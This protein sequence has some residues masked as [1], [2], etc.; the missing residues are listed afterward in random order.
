[1]ELPT[2]VPV[3]CRRV[4]SRPK[5]SAAQRFAAVALTAWVC[6]FSGAS[7]PV[8]AQDI[9]AGDAQWI[10][11]GQL[12]PGAAPSGEVYFRKKFNCGSPESARIEITAD[13]QY[14][15]YVNGR[16]VGN[17]QNWQRMDVYNVLSFVRNGTNV[18]AVKASNLSAGPAGL[19]V[20]V[21]VRN[22]GNTDVSHSTDQSWR[23]SLEA[24][25]HWQQPNFA[26]NDWPA[27]RVLGELGRTA[28]WGDQVQMPQGGAGGRFRIAPDFR[29]ER[30]V[31]P[32]LAGSIVAMAFNEAGNLI[33][34]RERGPLYLISDED[35]NGAF[36]TA[37]V[38]CEA[39]KNCQ[40]ILPL[41]G[42]VFAVGDGPDKAALYVLED[43]DRDGAAEKV[44]AILKFK[45]NM[46]EHGPHAPVLGPDGLIYLII[47]NHASADVQFES[48]SPHLKYYEGDLVQPKYEDAGGHAHGI[49]AP[50]GTV[51]RTDV[52]GSF[53][54]LYC[55][56]FRNAYDIAFNRQG[57]VFTYDS[58][59][60]W[61]VGLPW[62]RPTRVNHL[63]PGSEFGW[64]S[65]WSKWPAYFADTLPATA[66]I[67]RGSPTGVEFYNHQMFPARY[68]N[69]LFAADWSMGRI[70]AVRL[71]AENGTY[72]ARSEVF[73]QGRPLNVTDLAV[74]PDGWLYFST[75]GRGTEG[76]VYRIRWLGQVP[77]QPRH[78]GLTAALKQPQLYSAWGRNRAANLKQQTGEAWDTGL[79][80][81]ARDRKAPVDDRVRALDLMQLVGPFPTPE[82][83]VDTSRD[84]SPELRF[85]SAYLMGIHADGASGARLV[86]L[87]DDPHPNVQRQACESLTRAGQAAPVEKLLP[88]LA[89]PHRYL[90]WSARRAL[91]RLPREQ[92]ANQAL[93]AENPRVMLIGSLGLLFADPDRETIDRILARCS[94]AMQ[95]FLE[96]DDF[97]TLLRVVQVA[98]T[99]SGLTGDD[100]SDLR[101]QLAE[102]YPSLD[103]RMNREL[104]R[105]LAYL[106][107]SSIIPR[108]LAELANP[109]IPTVEKLHTATHARFL[110][111]GWEPAERLD[112]LKF[113]E[114]ARTLPGGHSFKGY[115]DNVSRDFVTAMPEAELAQIMDNALEVPTA[116]LS[117]L[118]RLP[119]KPND[120]TL[121]RLIQMDR[122]LKAVDSEAAR[123]LG[124]GI[125]AILGSSRTPESMAYLREAFDRDPAR[126]EDL[127]MGLAQE[128]GG[129]NFAY[130][131]KALPIV[132]GAAGQ[133]VLTKLAEV[134]ARPEDAE[135]LRQ[136]I[137]CGLKLQDK[138]GALAARVLE[139]WTGEQRSQP[140]DKWD[141][142]L[143]SWQ[144]WFAEKYP[145]APPA[146]LPTNTGNKYTL[147][148]LLDYVK[149]P[150]VAPNAGRGEQVFVKAQ[151]I[152]CHRYGNRG[153]GLGPDLSSVSQRFQKKEILESILYPSLIISDQYASKTIATT[154]GLTY[155]GIVDPS[156]PDALVVLQSNG[157]KQSIPK[158]Q[159]E[160]ISPSNKSAMPEGLFDELTLEEIADLL[161]YLSRP[162]SGR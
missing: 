106:Q 37:K 135:T 71:R 147:Q 35:R 31:E 47:G 160:Q 148:E 83:L 91:E 76:G 155:T 87:L 136:T 12:A 108:L 33:V 21:S 16:L 29:V 10:W 8:R 161:V 156:Q 157:Q 100:V 53:V 120:E 122:E 121:G 14:E 7:A 22:Q 77:P 9:S 41:N 23:S 24:P 78:A 119:D 95:G 143:A 45:G 150:A 154:D 110:A 158:E 153:E 146:A 58:D 152:K 55:G 134:D 63:T 81:V 131:L 88:L 114:Y 69:A 3:N 117:V 6:F 46:G 123:T 17:G 36:E 44:N 56:G 66:D 48:T 142:A 103:W 19:A 15:L 27:A 92:W 75:G 85:K 68:H 51:I 30:V 149:S 73:L 49:K 137:L 89:S 101:A 60:E 124:T 107:E 52:T 116:C 140:E 25:R 138:G 43:A 132:E 50:G 125:V 32:E 139:R 145:H 64:R 28:P 82:L 40:G 93:T 115:M 20:R 61:D 34:S 80:E 18:V 11:S 104:V 94:E 1:M 86:E 59:M 162:P 13:D 141:V 26:D 99:R 42:S 112:L 113:L 67:G 128:P 38:Y 98:L 118:R 144:Q 65:G 133:E 127:A 129:E 39:V 90:T 84:E 159:I 70:V 102:E 62:Y 109:E 5:N 130:L 105:L 97:L 74:G 151:C 72:V 57:D 96:D 126:R 54:E 111:Q 2:A 4:S 79:I